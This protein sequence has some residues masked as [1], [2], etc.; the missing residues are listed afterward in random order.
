MNIKKV[1][2]QAYSL[3]KHLHHVKSVNELPYTE[4]IN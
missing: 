1:T 4:N 3:V 2:R